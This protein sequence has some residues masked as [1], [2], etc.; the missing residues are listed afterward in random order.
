MFAVACCGGEASVL[1]SVS[2]KDETDCWLALASA[3]SAQLL[4]NLI[5][6]GRALQ[7]QYPSSIKQR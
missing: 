7:E 1:V 3:G 5:L 6:V 2:V 4:R